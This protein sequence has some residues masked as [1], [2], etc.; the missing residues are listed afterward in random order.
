MQN[1][2]QIP[3]WN[4]G[5]EDL[6]ELGR[7]PSIHPTATVLR[8]KLG[9]WTEVGAFAEILDSALDDYTYLAPVHCSINCADIG[10]FCSIASSVRINPVQHPMGRIAQHHCTYRRRQY[11]FGSADDEAFFAWRRHHRVRIGHDVWIGH[12]AIIMPGVRIETGAVIGAG[13]V[14]TRN[15]PAFAVAAGVPA[16]ILR[17]RFPEETADRILASDWWNWPHETI[18]ER[19]ADLIHPDR[20]FREEV[21]ARLEK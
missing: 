7:E 16:R 3:E 2:H 21:L 20:M 4:R 1:A 8:S 15:V 14:V 9:A 10:K 12:G 17:M 13:A 5:V 6:P 19:L 18:R 11:G